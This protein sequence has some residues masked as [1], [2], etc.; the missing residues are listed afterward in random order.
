MTKPQVLLVRLR[1]NL[2]FSLAQMGTLLGVREKDLRAAEDG[3]FVLPM[4]AFYAAS[5]TQGQEL[6][7]FLRGSL[8]E[9]N[10]I[11]I[12]RT[13]SRDVEFE[14]E[15]KVPLLLGHLIHRSRFVRGLLEVLEPEGCPQGLYGEAFES[16]AQDLH[17]YGVLLVCSGE[18]EVSSL[19]RA[20]WI[21]VPKPTLFI[22]PHCGVT[23]E[24]LVDLSR[25]LGGQ[26]AHVIYN[27]S[28][29]LEKPV[30]GPYGLRKGFFRYLVVEGLKKS[31][32]NRD[33]A[34][35]LLGIPVDEG[36]PEVPGALGEPLVPFEWTL[37]QN[38]RKFLD[39][40]GLRKWS[41]AGAERD[42]LYWKIPLVPGV[43]V[44]VSP[45][46]PEYFL[47]FNSSGEL[48]EFSLP[49]Q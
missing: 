11:E 41:P 35:S 12:F 33:Q 13:H 16:L 14:S 47:S 49:K 32:I 10:P 36:L 26:K 2:G 18:G 1:Q 30:M 46:S 25:N 42:G 34:W 23:P 17:H 43:G 9:P 22:N 39:S 19:I 7:E 8:A 44:F 45:K 29:T 37:L 15:H 6:Q 40:R 31:L 48:T 21:P 20:A 28:G 3:T 27:P 38:A 4:A 24:V 5:M